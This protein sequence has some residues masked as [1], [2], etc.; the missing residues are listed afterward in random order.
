MHISKKF[1]KFSLST[2]ENCNIIFVMEKGIIIERGSHN[3]LIDQNGK[4]NQLHRS[5]KK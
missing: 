4:Y 3:E 2:V 1:Y 5:N